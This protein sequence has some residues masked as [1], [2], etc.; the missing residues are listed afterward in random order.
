[1]NPPEFPRQ[2]PSPSDIQSLEVLARPVAEVASFYQRARK[3]AYHYDGLLLDED[4]EGR[5]MQELG[6][7][8][9]VNGLE[10]LCAVCSLGYSY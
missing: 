2:T 5:M 10:G 6:E 4:C 8:Q 1:M 3:E 9:R 7:L